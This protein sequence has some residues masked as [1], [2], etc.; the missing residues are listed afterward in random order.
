MDKQD[1]HPL[2]DGL[3][4]GDGAVNVSTLRASIPDARLRSIAVEFDACVAKLLDEPF[5]VR[6]LERALE[7]ESEARPAAVYA[8]DSYH[9]FTCEFSPWEKQHVYE[10]DQLETMLAKAIEARSGET[11]RLD[12]QGESAVAKPFAQG[13]DS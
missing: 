5:T 11:E 4:S 9:G 13:A 1:G 12:P 6:H 10:Y 7:N 8:V 2:R 3:S